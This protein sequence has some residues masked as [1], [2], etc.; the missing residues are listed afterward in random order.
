MGF[1]SAWYLVFAAPFILIFAFLV[2]AEIRIIRK[3]GYSGWWI[4]TILI[5]VVNFIMIYVFAFSTWPRDKA[6][7]A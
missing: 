3:A 1:I 6:P 2:W 4:L 7:N 5:P